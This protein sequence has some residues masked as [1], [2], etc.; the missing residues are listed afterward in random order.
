M[1]DYTFFLGHQP[2][3]SLAELEARFGASTIQ[4]F[5]TTYAILKLNQEPNINLLGG[6]PRPMF[7]L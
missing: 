2:H 7:I 3:L 5:T 6:T 4:E 1:H